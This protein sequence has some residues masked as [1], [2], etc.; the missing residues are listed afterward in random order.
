MVTILKGFAILATIV[1]ASLIW[2][3]LD[4]EAPRVTEFLRWVFAIAVLIFC[5]VF[6]C[7]GL[8]LVVEELTR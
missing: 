4:E 5:I 2:T 6:I 8:G 1:F 7:Y 3:A